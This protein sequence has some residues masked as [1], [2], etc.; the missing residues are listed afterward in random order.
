MFIRKYW[1]PLSVF[2][3]AIC[4]VGLYYLQTQPPKEPIVIYKP[5]EPIEK[6]TAEVPEGDTSQ[7]GHVHA[8]GTW[9][10]GPHE[11]EAP[12]ESLVE[13]LSTEEVS[14]PEAETS[15]SFE[16]LFSYTDDEISKMTRDERSEIRRNLTEI[17]IH[18]SGEKTAVSGQ[19]MS[20]VDEMNQLAEALGAGRITA[21]EWSQKYTEMR[22][23]QS[24]LQQKSQELSAERERIRQYIRRLSQ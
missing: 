11:A 5:V 18:V 1:I 8:D 2:I 12:V 24:E 21:R 22:K 14:E 10:E 23:R 20:L 17:M 19:R 15:V 4:G 6:P 3:V 16:D 13:P 9:H 7:G